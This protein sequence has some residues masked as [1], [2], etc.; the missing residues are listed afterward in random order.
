MSHANA[1]LTPAGRFVM[2]ERIEAGRPVAHVAAEMGVSRT[3]AWRWWRRYRELGRAGLVDRPS[4][5]LSH[6]HRTSPCVETR[7]RIARMLSRRGPV[8]IGHHLSLAPSTVGRVLARH[9]ARLLRECDPV[10]GLPIRAAR[11]SAARYEHPYPGSLIHVDVK[12]LGRIPDGG[13]WRAHGREATVTAKSKRAPIGYDYV[14]TAIDDH[15]R[16]AYAEIHDDEKGTTAAGFLARAATFYA[17]HGIRIER[18]IS[19][20]A[21]AYRNS[22]EFKR[23]AADL[24]IVQKFIR[25]HCP[26]TNGKVERLNRTLA[27]EWAYRRPWTSTT[28]RAAALPAWLEHYN[29]DRPHLGIGGQRP[30]DRVN[31]AAGQYT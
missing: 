28:E 11:A 12:K 30:I 1:R 15:S 27:T 10:T 17:S 8:W 22:R 6:P 14:H 25:P 21:F 16:L 3:T 4:R 20:N 9:R 2:V 31:N 29:L 26:W 5:P 13:G 7:I 18:V 23:V 24:G 19:D